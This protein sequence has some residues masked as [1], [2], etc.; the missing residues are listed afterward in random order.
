MNERGHL[1]TE[2]LDLM[3]LEALPSGENAEATAHLSTCLGCRGEW[4]G[5]LSDQDYFRKHVM[6]RRSEALAA[7]SR[8]GPSWS[9]RWLTPAVAL[10]AVV[11][12][13]VNGSTLRHVV[14]GS[15]AELGF[16]GGPAL[17]VFAK[18]GE[19][20]FAVKPGVRLATGDRLRFV[21]EPGSARFLLI[22]SIDG[23]GNVSPLFPTLA[24]AAGDSDHRGE[25]RESAPVSLGRQELPGSVELDNA[26]GPESVF[27]WFTSQPISF[28]EASAALRARPQDPTIRGAKPLRIVLEKAK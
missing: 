21:I 27:A 28:E 19:A 10:A 16:K 13:A 11:A 23:E 9:W 25:K 7:D 17:E 14:A 1:S 3:L 15:E 22:A 4:E 12:V 6:P 5:R 26:P 8:R 24:E 20:V 18:R 2:S